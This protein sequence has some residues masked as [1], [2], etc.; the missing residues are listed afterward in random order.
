MALVAGAADD[1]IASR[2]DA[3]LAGVGLGAGVGVRSGGRGGG[4]GGRSGGWR[5]HARK[6]DVELAAGAPAGGL[7]S[8]ADARLT[9]VGLGEGIG[10]LARRSVGRGR[11]RAAA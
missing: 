1:G 11:V 10:V 3:R 4:S 7:A 8:G 6:R 5:W 2:A 9:N